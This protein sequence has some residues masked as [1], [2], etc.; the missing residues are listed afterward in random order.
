MRV[1][2]AAGTVDD[3]AARID[4]VLADLIPSLSAS[5]GGEPADAR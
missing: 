2:D 1:V 4:A 5:D 3:V